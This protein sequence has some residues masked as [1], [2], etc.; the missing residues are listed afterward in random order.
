MQWNYTKIM[1]SL[2]LFVKSLER[3]FGKQSQEITKGESF[4]LSFDE[5]LEPIELIASDLHII[6]H[7]KI[8]KIPP[9][10]RE[11]LPFWLYLMRANFLG[12]GVKGT[13]LGSDLGLEWVTLSLVITYDINY[14]IFK[15]RLEEFLNVQ[16]Y[17]NVEIKN[18][19]GK[20]V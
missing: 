3:D 18:F 2:P 10:M 14:I 1:T 16:D 11:H 8:A 4:L 13:T 7:A 17:W 20:H 19:T 6:L 15:E 5:N 9:E 12:Q